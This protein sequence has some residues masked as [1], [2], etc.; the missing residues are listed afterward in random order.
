VIATPTGQLVLTSLRDEDR[1]PV[2]ARPA[3]ARLMR[4]VFAVA[5]RRCFA[6][7]D[8][9][10]NT[11]YV[12]DLLERRG[13]PSDGVFARET[14]AV[15]RSVLG[16]PDLVAGIADDRRLGM[17]ILVVGDLARGAAD[18]GAGSD[19]ELLEALVAQ[20]ETRV[21]RFASAE[22]SDGRPWRRRVPR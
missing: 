9:R 7:R 10:D 18:E 19:A 15:I 3:S 16:E 13:V 8:P 11:S 20:A 6:G 22:P 5:V 12:K 2:G 4:E 1:D 14:E 21:A 17:M